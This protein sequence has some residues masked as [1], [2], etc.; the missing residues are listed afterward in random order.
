MGRNGINTRQLKQF[1][2]QL[3]HLKNGMDYFINDCAK[4]LAAR[5]IRELKQRTPVGDTGRLRGSWQSSGTT[6]SGIVYSIRVINETEYAIYVEYGHRTRGGAGWVR[7]RFMLTISTD[8][9]RQNT[10]AILERKIAQ[11][12]GEYLK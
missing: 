10:P 2:T 9:L 6:K 12:L 7:G 5:L 4:E 11:K 8:E 1:R 3:M